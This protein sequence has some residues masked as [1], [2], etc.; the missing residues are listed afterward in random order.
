MLKSSLAYQIQQRRLP[1]SPPHLKT[2]EESNTVTLRFDNL[3]Q[4]IM[5]KINLGDK[6]ISNI[7]MCCQKHL[8]KT[9][10][11]DVT[12]KKKLRRRRCGKT[13]MNK[14][15]SLSDDHIMWKHLRKKILAQ[16]FFMFKSLVKIDLPV[17]LQLFCC[18]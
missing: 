8:E 16:S 13:R 15:A 17:S 3:N 1:P 18:L 12:Q 4:L 7:T 5:D 10:R 14:Q 11:K 6:E 2:K 9:V